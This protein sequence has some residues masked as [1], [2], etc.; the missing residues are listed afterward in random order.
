MSISWWENT[1]TTYNGEPVY[2]YV[3]CPVCRSMLGRRD[4]EDAVSF[5][6]ED[7]KA[8]Y[9]FYPGISK[10]LSKLDKD[11]AQTCPCPGCRY[12]RGEPDEE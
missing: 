8:V 11:I 5:H 12:K 2:E 3:N 4:K 6:C 7:C 10:P 1:N 9:T